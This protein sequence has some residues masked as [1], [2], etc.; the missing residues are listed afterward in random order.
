MASLIANE[1]P[2]ILSSVTVGG[3]Q[4]N[5]RV[6]LAPLTRSRCGLDEVPGPHYV[7]YFTQRSSAGLLITDATVISKQGKG[8]DGSPS[9]YDGHFNFLF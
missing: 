4:L 8:F 1:S 9:I 5:N 7:E 3:I 2:A 6:A